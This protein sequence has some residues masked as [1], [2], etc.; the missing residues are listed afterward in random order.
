M[1]DVQIGRSLRAL[2]HRRR[3]RQ[4][5]VARQA[6]VSQQ[7]VSR[8]ER[9]RI[10]PV[11]RDTLARIFAT[12]DATVT[13]TVRW[14]GGELDRLLDEGHASLAGVVTRL[15]ADLGWDVLP[16]VTFSEWGERGS[17]DILA[18]HSPTRTLLV[19]E[20]KTEIAGA[21]EMLRA[22]DVK[23][24]LAPKL[25]QARFGLAPRQVA[26]LLVVAEGSTNRR[27]IERLDPVLR[28]AYPVRGDA[29]RAWL[30]APVSAIAGLL[31]TASP[32]S[33]ARV[34]R[35]RVRPRAA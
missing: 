30:R 29:V 7:L 16:E 1:N 10:G 27:R 17:V 4:V 20:I 14:H 19:V 11:A 6:G 21:E 13:T 28:A 23:V 33:V 35:H 12:V 32:A 22:H 5:D 8:V 25:G 9:G 2:R 18:W 15:L 3:L 31:V 26:R 34:N 24:R